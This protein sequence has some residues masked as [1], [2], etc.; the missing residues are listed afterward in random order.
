MSNVIC[1]FCGEGN[2][3]LIGL[4]A[5]YMHERCPVF[6]QTDT[7]TEDFERRRQQTQAEWT[8]CFNKAIAEGNAKCVRCNGT[9]IS[10]KEAQP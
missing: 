5:H 1:P 7:L 4:R 8:D 6:E 2:F 3:D 9:G 10:R